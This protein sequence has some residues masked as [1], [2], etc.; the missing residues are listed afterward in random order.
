MRIFYKQLNKFV[1][2]NVRKF[3]KKRFKKRPIHPEDNAD[4][5]LIN[6]L[7]LSHIIVIIINII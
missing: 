7:I 6:G 3:A 5:Q 1:C 4:G 2:E